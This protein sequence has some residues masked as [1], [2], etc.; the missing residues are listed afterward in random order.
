MPYAAQPSPFS[1]YVNF[2]NASKIQ[3]GKEKSG[4]LQGPWEH[5]RITG[6]GSTS[7]LWD[8]SQAMN[9]LHHIITTN[10]HRNITE[11]MLSRR[12]G[13]I[14]FPDS[15][16]VSNIHYSDYEQI[17]ISGTIQSS[18]AQKGVVLPFTVADTIHLVLPMSRIIAVFREPIS[19]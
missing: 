6:D 2:F 16:N 7:T 17:K 3:E 1:E 14:T 15:E 12:N 19:R 5:P 18:A 10:K 9:Y 4:E 8:S 11:V 13:A